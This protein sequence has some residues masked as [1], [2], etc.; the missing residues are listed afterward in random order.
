MQKMGDLMEINMLEK[1]S[2]DMVWTSPPDLTLK[3]SLLGTDWVLF[4]L[5]SFHTNQS[6]P[7][8]GKKKF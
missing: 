2:K 3:V 5:K 7:L 6:K 8:G 4:Y 1:D